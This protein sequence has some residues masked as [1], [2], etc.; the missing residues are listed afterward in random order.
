MVDVDEH[1]CYQDAA[2]Q[3]LDAFTSV[4]ESAIRFNHKN[5][6][7]EHAV[8]IATGFINAK[9]TK[10]SSDVTA[11][12]EEEIAEH[13]EPDH[14]TFQDALQSIAIISREVAAAA[15]VTL[16]AHIDEL[17]KSI[18]HHLQQGS[19]EST[20]A[21]CFEQ[22]HWL[23]L[24]AGNIIADGDDGEVPSPPTSIN[25]ACSGI[26]S[27]KALVQALVTAVL[28]VDSLSTE[29][30][31]SGSHFSA[32]LVATIMWFLRRWAATY[33]WVSQQSDSF[34]AALTIWGEGTA[35]GITMFDFLLRKAWTL[36][37]QWQGEPN[38][39][40]EAVATLIM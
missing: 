38:I 2:E 33:L 17:L 6:L 7:A 1:D 31:K 12:L 22:M 40:K 10:A 21:V 20:Q 26:G 18:A 5:L 32:T 28:R 9:M 11:L 23:L 25:D 19:S 15:I 39:V 27:G 30:L 14:K 36:L 24:I 29:G 16:T 13:E 37:V 4:A 35:D 8:A 34:Q 3:L